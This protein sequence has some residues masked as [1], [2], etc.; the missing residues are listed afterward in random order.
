MLSIDKVLQT[1][2][3]G[4][5]RLGIDDMELKVEYAEKR[6]RIGKRAEI[7]IWSK[8]LAKI[9]LYPDATLFSVRHELC[10]A[11]LFRMGI[12]LTNTEKDLE[13]CPN[14]IDYM[15]MV[16]IVE[17]YINELQKRVFN[18]YYTVDEAGTPRPPPFPGLPEL[19]KEKFSTIQ[20]KQIF[21]DCLNRFSQNNL[22]DKTN[23]K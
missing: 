9:V 18:E 13:L 15:Q 1:I 17:W 3:D 22:K 14:R 16:I 6:S 12:P 23:K 5:H 11:K 10:H 21:H 7:F 4:K 20:I 19:P 2:K 8:S